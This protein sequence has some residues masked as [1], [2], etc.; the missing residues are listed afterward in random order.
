LAWRHGIAISL[1]SCALP[2]ADVRAQNILVVIAD[3]LGVDA[4]AAYGESP[5]A[6]P[7]PV[8][9]ALATGGVL[10]RNFWTQPV[11]S[12]TRASLL[13]GLNPAR[14]GL[15]GVVDPNKPG[16]DVGM[17]ASLPNLASHLV[18]EGYRSFALGKWHLAGGSEPD[19]EHPL[20]TG[21]D[22]HAGTI[23]PS[24]NYF[25]WQ[26]VTKGVQ[27]FSS[28]YKTTDTT[29]DAIAQIAGSEPWFGWVAYDA[30]HSPFHE[31]PSDLHSFDLT[32]SPS[33]T[34]LYRAMVEALDTELGRLLAVVDLSD[35][36]VI[37]LGDNGTPSEVTETPFLPNHAKRTLYEGGVNTPLIVAGQAVAAA[38]VGQESAALVE[39]TDLLAT[40]LEV[41]SVT[42]AAADSTS[43]AAFLDEPLNA[44]QRGWVFAETFS[45]NGGPIDPATHDRTVRNDID[46]K[47][48]RF[49]DG[50][51]ELYDLVADPFEQ[52]PLDLMNLSPEEENAYG[53]LDTILQ[54]VPEP[55]GYGPVIATWVVVALLRRR[56]A[57]MNSRNARC[58][59]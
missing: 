9:D 4:V 45:P 49:G 35:T 44:S 47:L 6:G 37:F 41:V 21:F 42:G 39:A 34:L 50:S 48:L 58:E 15:G 12:P 18:V 2:V 31:P 40:V 43:F 59:A 13:T 55:D 24:G 22:Y 51:D 14:H 56:F 26:K 33:D 53:E 57:R 5:N 36:T 1:L 19:L 27:N 11:C 38:A 52:N 46:Y 20:L 25:A 28:T 17:D 32:G 29:D 23:M 8:I 16:R 30:P 7:T 3:D 54:T 10:F